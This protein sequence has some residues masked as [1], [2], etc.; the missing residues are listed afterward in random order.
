M[1]ISRHLKVVGICGV[2]W[3]A[4]IGCNDDGDRIAHSGDDDDSAGATPSGGKSSAGTSNGGTSNGGSSN[5]GSSNG[6]SSNGGKARTA[7]TAGSA[8]AGQGGISGGVPNAGGASGN[9]NNAGEAG[10]IET[11]VAGAGGATEAAGGAGGAGGAAAGQSGA[12]GEGVFSTPP[13]PHCAYSC[14][15]DDDCLIEDDDTVKCNLTLQRCEDPS[16]ACT[17]DQD[18]LVSLSLWFVSCANDSG[19]VA[20]TQACVEASGH[21]YCAKLPGAGAP[22]CAGPTVPKQLARFGASGTIEVCASADPRCSAGRCRKGC[23]DAAAGCGLG[24]GNTC[25]AATGLCECSNG[26]EC[27]KTGICGRDR[28]C[29]ACTINADCPNA[30][31]TAC[32]EGKCGCPN[33]AACSAADPGY[34][35][36]SAVCQ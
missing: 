28:H 29:Q 4:A 11:P 32:L 17:A 26:S 18:C 3:L 30:P 27:T 10:T 15:S 19:C 1:A 2:A 20:N 14:A 16:Q 31:D 7:G 5:G 25:N 6:G 36:A 22:A 33:A 8:N 23:G 9:M 21:G 13:A 12:G 35:S 24:K 34:A